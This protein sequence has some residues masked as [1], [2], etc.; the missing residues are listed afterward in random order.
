MPGV[1][2]LQLIQAVKKSYASEFLAEGYPP[3]V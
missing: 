2:P 3:R 1:P